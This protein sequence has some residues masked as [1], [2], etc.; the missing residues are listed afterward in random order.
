MI[1]GSLADTK[2][3]SQAAYDKAREPKELFVIE[4]ATHVDL[5]DKPQFVN[6]AVEKL[7]SFFDA[8]L[9]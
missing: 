3:F 2:H 8:Y 4:G 6:Q 7:T 5:Y 1:I 9:K